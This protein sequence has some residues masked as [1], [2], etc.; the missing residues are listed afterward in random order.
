[1]TEALALAG[2]PTIPVRLRRDGERWV[3]DPLASWSWA[4]TDP[5]TLEGWWRR[6][7]EALPGVPLARVGWAVI[8]VDDDD[9]VFWEIWNGLGPRGPYSKIQT[10]SGGWHF[11]FTQ[12]PERVA[13]FKWS[14]AV[15]VLGTA[16]VLTIYDVE[17]ILFPR[18][19][20]RAVLPEVFRKPWV[21]REECPIKKRR[22]VTEPAAPV[23]VADASAAM[24]K[25]NPCDWNSDYYGWFALLTG[26]KF[27][28]I[29][30]EEFIA[31]SIG[32]PVYA[33]DARKIRRMWEACEPRHG[34]AFH[35]ALATRGIR[36]RERSGL[37]NGAHLSAEPTR[38]G[39]LQSRTRGL[40]GWLSRNATGDGS[41]SVAC[42]FAELGLTQAITTKLIDGNLP[43]LRKG[44]GDAEFNRQIANAFRHVKEKR[45]A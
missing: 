44:L 6:W 18:V 41:F 33:A 15:E 32:D 19:A 14:E 36:L 2:I 13:R 35:A 29:G 40:I 26:A 31:W 3:K 30:R 20:P 11:V 22:A 21:G 42:L 39:N 17:E 1:M 43:S 27:V 28:G 25:M 16:S 34:G 24:R 38:P 45:S 12:P 10:P 7:P 37:F 5:E 8:D 9:P 4:T 23:R